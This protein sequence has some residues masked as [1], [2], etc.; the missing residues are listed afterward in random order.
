MART[1]VQSKATREQPAPSPRLRGMATRLRV[2]EASQH[3]ARAPALQR[4]AG[5]AC[6]GEAAGVAS[7]IGVMQANG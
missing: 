2:R 1:E 3:R 6:P 7:L 4:A 5:S